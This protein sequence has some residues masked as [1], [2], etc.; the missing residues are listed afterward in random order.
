MSTIHFLMH[1]NSIVAEF[2]NFILT[3]V[4][5]K[6]KLPLLLQRCSDLRV[7]MQTREPDV[8]RASIS[9]ICDSLGVSKYDDFPLGGFVNYACVTDNYWIKNKSENKSWKDVKVCHTSSSEAFLGI[10]HGFS[11]HTQQEANFT[12][13]GSYEKAWIQLLNDARFYLVKRGTLEERFSEILYSRLGKLFGFDVVEYSPWFKDTIICENFVDTGIYDFEHIYNVVDFDDDYAKSYNKIKEIAPGEELRF[14]Q[15]IF[16]DTIC[17]NMDRHTFNYGLLRNIE[18]GEFQFAPIYDNNISLLSALELKRDVKSVPDRQLTYFEICLKNLC[19]D[20][21]ILENY[22]RR[23]GVPKFC[24]SDIQ[25]VV[26]EVINHKSDDFKSLE[27][28]EESLVEYIWYGCQ[29]VSELFSEYSTFSKTN[30]F[31]GDI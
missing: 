19:K 17:F 1:R 2:D 8:S 20:Q 25:Q 15:M 7:W 30:N 6:D 24:K 13:I 23:F 28:F 5:I 9:N 14:L 11:E 3:R 29:F 16:L 12:L 26:H 27:C 4:F 31:V 21:T 22:A 10:D 18:T